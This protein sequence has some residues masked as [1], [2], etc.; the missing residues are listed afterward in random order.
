MYLTIRINKRILFTFCLFLMVLIGIIFPVSFS[1]TINE[2]KED[3]IELPIIMYHGITK[4]QK[5]LG[6]YVISLEEFESD[7]RYIN[8]NGYTTVFVKDVIDYVYNNTPLPSKPLMITFDDGYYNNYL[9]A[10]PLLKQY[11]CKMVLSPIGKCVDV[12]SQ[13]DDKNPNYA[14]TSWDD[15][16]EMIQSG[17]VEIQNHSYDMHTTKKRNGAKKIIGESNEGYKKVL[18]EDLMKMQDAI[19]NNTGI[20]AEAFTYP[21]GAVSNDSINILKELGFKAALTCEGKI[22]QITH[23]KDCLYKLNRFI[24]PHNISAEELFIKI[25]RK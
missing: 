4:R 21:F 16:N 18:S 19:V 7:L 20:Q 1:T 25:S 9:Y 22:N 17:L 23:N 12:Y 6:K 2:D 11:E 13:K 10:Y 8:T 5:C 14:H 15:I 3:Y 24:R